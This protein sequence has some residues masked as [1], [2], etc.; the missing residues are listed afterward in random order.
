MQLAAVIIPPPDVVEDAL[1]VAR[2]LVAAAPEVAPRQQ[3]PGLLGRLLGRPDEEEPASIGL[4]EPEPSKVFVRLVK[5]GHVSDGD[6]TSLTGALRG[7]A[8]EWVAP[9]LHVSS[10]SIE[11]GGPPPVRA[12][13]G[14]DVE[15]LRSMV[16]HLDEAAAQHGLTHKRRGLRPEFSLGALDVP[17]RSA[18]AARSPPPASSGDG[19][20]SPPTSRWSRPTRPGAARCTSRSPACHSPRTR[21][22]TT[23]TYAGSGAACAA[24]RA[25]AAR[26]GPAARPSRRRWRTRTTGG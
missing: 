9:V 25:A 12:H 10:V 18:A 4:Y 20:G 11:D 15:V 19:T 23:P 5:L 1:V 8:E 3:R 6:A 7:L 17:W 2:G 13:L 21:S 14:G 26:P 16:A 24:S 22:G